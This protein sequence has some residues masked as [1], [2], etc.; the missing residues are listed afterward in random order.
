MSAA[1][2]AVAQSDQPAWAADLYDRTEGMVEV[3]NGNVSKIDLGV[4]GD[5]LANERVNFRISDG[6]EE[7]VFSF[8]MDGNNRITQL[9][10]GPRDDATLVMETDRETVEGIIEARNPAAAFRD[11]VLDDEITISGVGAVNG[12]KWSAINVVSDAA[13][14]FD[15]I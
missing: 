1:A 9:S 14:V 5:Q 13:R 11:A 3:Y 8:R 2:P 7:A 4:A 12:V 10:P 6:D 15:L